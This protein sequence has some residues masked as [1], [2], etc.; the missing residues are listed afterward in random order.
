MRLYSN[1]STLLI[2][3]TMNSRITTTNSGFPLKYLSNAKC[4]FINEQIGAKML[5]PKQESISIGAIL[6][7]QTEK[8]SPDKS[9]SKGRSLKLARD[10]ET[11][12]STLDGDTPVK[13]AA[14]SFPYL[15]EAALFYKTAGNE[16]NYLRV[17]AQLLES[18]LQLQNLS[19]PLGTKK[20]ASLIKP[21]LPPQ[22][23]NGKSHSNEAIKLPSEVLIA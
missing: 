15:V 17:C 12:A 20:Y 1:F 21:H 8:F 7:Y 16:L 3:E 18:E 11:Y 10:Y 14:A 19:P 6:D 23:G 5:K 22:N 13:V 9:Y 4:G 2:G